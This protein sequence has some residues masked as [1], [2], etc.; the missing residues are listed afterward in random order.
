MQKRSLVRQATRFEHLSTLPTDEQN[1]PK[2]S[3]YRVNENI[4]QFALCVNA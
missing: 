4:R 3:T 1:V 2:P